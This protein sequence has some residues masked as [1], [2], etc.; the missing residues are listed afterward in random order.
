MAATSS[1][2][3]SNARSI[4]NDGRD[5]AAD[6]PMAWGSR[7]IIV[8]KQLRFGFIRPVSGRIK[9]CDLFFHAEHCKD[10]YDVLFLNSEV[11][12]R[13]GWND[14]NKCVMAIQVECI[15]SLRSPPYAQLAC[16]L[17]IQPIVSHFATPSRLSPL[18]NQQK[19]TQAYLPRTSP[20]VLPSDVYEEK[21]AGRTYGLGVVEHRRAV[22]RQAARLVEQTAD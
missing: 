20:I 21:L 10:R 12:Y 22:G 19:N 4:F 5:V 16:N 7:G 3:V 14:R 13:V 17:W 8:S 9:G 2:N 15:A 1:A 6:D 11:T 18:R